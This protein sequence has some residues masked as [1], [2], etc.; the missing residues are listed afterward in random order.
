MSLIF[1]FLIP[2]QTV[3]L[4]LC[5]EKKSPGQSVIS[6]PNDLTVIASNTPALWWD[7][8]PVNVSF[9]P[10]KQISDIIFLLVQQGIAG[11]HKQADTG[12]LLHQ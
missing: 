3:D 2:S 12:K 4:L 6:S 5:L 9:H 1:L 8:V 7:L 11:F 10:Q